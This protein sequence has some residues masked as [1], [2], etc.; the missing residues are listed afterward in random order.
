MD[1]NELYDAKDNHFIVLLNQYLD[2]LISDNEKYK[3]REI[4]P[5]YLNQD[6]ILYKLFF[7][8]NYLL[9]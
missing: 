9:F 6:I 8:I 3:E 7:F 4:D 1:I 2:L 5:E